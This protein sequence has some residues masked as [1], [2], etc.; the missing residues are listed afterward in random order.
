MSCHEATRHEL[1]L[2]E[3][4][5]CSSRGNWKV[6]FPSSYLA[7]FLYEW[8][9]RAKQCLPNVYCRKYHEIERVRGTFLVV[10][11]TR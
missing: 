3:L 2:R 9:F 10:F 11:T 8:L 1:S 5:L 6:F 4:T 7:M